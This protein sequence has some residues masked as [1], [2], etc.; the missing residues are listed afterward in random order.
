LELTVSL[1]PKSHTLVILL[2]LRL[3]VEEELESALLAA[4]L[5]ADLQRLAPWRLLA[6]ISHL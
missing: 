2:A 3:S 5:P 6:L 4:L 1:R